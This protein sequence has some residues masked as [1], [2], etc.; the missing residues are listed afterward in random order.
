MSKKDIDLTGK[1]LGRLLVI[2]KVGIDRWMCRC[3]CGNEKDIRCDHLISGQIKSC[4]CLQAERSS[5]AST[6]HGLSGSSIYGIWSQIK[7]RCYRKTDKLYKFYG[8]RGIKMCKRWR[9]NFNDFYSDVG[10]RPSRLL[11]LDRK[12]NNGNYKPSNVRW[13][14]RNQQAQNKRTNVNITYKGKRQCIAVWAREVG[15]NETTLYRRIV[16]SNWS[17]KKAM[18][19]PTGRK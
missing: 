6:T 16:T 9:D 17:I 18:T 4:R 3:D 5:N 7:S 11:S 8:G 19:F 12:D 14:T 1:R 13:A 2:Y 15:I 10:E